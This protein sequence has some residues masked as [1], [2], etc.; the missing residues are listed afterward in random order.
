MKYILNV[1]AIINACTLLIFFSTDTL[2]SDISF[3]PRASISI[4]SYSFDQTAR[5][6]ALPDT[7]NGGEFPKVSFNVTFKTLGLGGTFFSNGYYLDLS[8][9]KSAQEE[10]DF[11][12]EDP[13]FTGFGISDGKFSETFKGDREDTAITLGKKIFDHQ[14]TVYLGYKTGK[15][16]ATGNQGE[17]LSF[18]ESGLFVGANYGWPIAKGRF[19]INLAFADLQGKLKEKVTYEPFSMLP[20]PLDINASSDAQ[21]LSYGLSWASRL[22]STLSYSIS[23]DTKKYT[24]DNVKDKN[25]SATPSSEFNEE[26]SSATVALYFQF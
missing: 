13:A 6:G 26:L 9:Q 21:G 11:T 10:D 22:S 8:A 7:I 1:S 25:P 2:A 15:S 19:S 4:A 16:S 5:P 3:S 14:G 18:K 23:L 20:E 24:F 12:F 17:T